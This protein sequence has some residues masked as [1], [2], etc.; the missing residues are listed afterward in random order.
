M[1]VLLLLFKQEI[2]LGNQ[3]TQLQDKLY[4]ALLVFF[5]VGFNRNN[6]YEL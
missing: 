3:Y 4:H 2:L 5:T 1:Q 6:L